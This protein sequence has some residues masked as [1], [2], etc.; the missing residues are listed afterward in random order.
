VSKIEQ[1]PK[2]QRWYVLVESKV[3]GPFDRAAIAG[4]VDRNQLLDNDRVH[5]E[6]G[7]EW[8]AAKQDVQLASLFANSPAAPPPRSRRRLVRWVS[9]AGKLAVLGGLAWIAWPY[10]AL[11]SL[12]TAVREA[13][14]ST[15]ERRVEWNSLRQSLRGDLNA[16]LLKAMSDKSK[17]NSDDAL[18]KG[19]TAVLGPAVINNMIDGYVTPQAVAAMVRNETSPESQ[20]NALP[21]I[22][23][24]KRV[25]DI[26]WEKVKYAFFSGGPF[27]FRVE[28]AEDKLA[29]QPVGLELSWKGDWR[30]VRIIIPQEVFDTPRKREDGPA[31]TSAAESDGYNKGA[32]ESLKTLL[33]SGT[34]TQPAPPPQAAVPSPI[35]LALVSK[36]YRNDDYRANPIVRA[37]I[38]F[39]LSVINKTNQA[40]RA[41][42][43]VIVFTDLLDNELLS[44]K[45]ALNDPVAANATVKWSGGIDYN[46][47]MNSHSR[48][49]SEATQ[50]IKIKFSPKKI[51]FS[52]GSAKQFE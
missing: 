4:M 15:L 26:D 50:N 37:A 46:Q 23:N 19:F 40:I 36:S 52:D 16:T 41:F 20:A 18:S 38:T 9:L 8:I 7:S 32:R 1:P 27:L 51:L 14:V 43:G 47:F 11:Y 48:L 25:K 35:E 49:R 3:Y 6:G 31:Q 12:M 34:P 17:G 45:F 28:I 29:K 22:K 10:Y 24:F 13:D 39:E 21:A 44:T 42:D 5:I 33:N 30:L 2:R